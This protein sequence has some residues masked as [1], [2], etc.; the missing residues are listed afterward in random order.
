MKFLMLRGQV[1]QDRDS[2]EIVF[3]TIEECDD[4]WTHLFFAMVKP[5]DQAELW[6]WNGNREHKFADNFT[7]F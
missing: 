4:T 2:Q 6:Y 3:N 1:P 7:A 5:G